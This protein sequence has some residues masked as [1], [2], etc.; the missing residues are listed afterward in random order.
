MLRV[1]PATLLALAL[2]APAAAGVANHSQYR[3]SGPTRYAVS[4][5]DVYHDQGVVRAAKRTA[6][7]KQQTVATQNV[8]GVLP[9]E[10]Y[11][12]LVVERSVD[13]LAWQGSYWRQDGAAEANLHEVEVREERPV[14]PIQG[15]TYPVEV[16]FR[17]VRR[18]PLFQPRLEASGQ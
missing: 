14:G 5:W 8:D 10:W 18:P 13:H 17:L 3:Q 6:K 7:W 4:I 2:A 11:G 1:V 15:G 16:S 12:P 9:G